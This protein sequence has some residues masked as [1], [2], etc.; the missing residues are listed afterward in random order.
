MFHVP[1]TISVGKLQ[2]LRHCGYLS[3]FSDDFRPSDQD[4]S[5]SENSQS[6][7]VKMGIIERIWKIGGIFTRGHWDN[8]GNRPKFK[9]SKHMKR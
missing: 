3:T 7:N 6:G 5:E 4:F 8:F 9:N 2:R 1:N